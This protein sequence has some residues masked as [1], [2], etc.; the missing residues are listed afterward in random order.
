MKLLLDFCSDHSNGI[1]CIVLRLLAEI[2]GTDANVQAYI[3]QGQKYSSSC[4]K[5]VD[6]R[7][8]LNMMNASGTNNT[9]LPLKVKPRQKY[10]KQ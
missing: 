8:F 7:L 1:T 10:K 3:F 4:E 5:I 2:S 9:N 6:L